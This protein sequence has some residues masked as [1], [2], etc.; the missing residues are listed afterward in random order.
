MTPRA[1]INQLQHVLSLGKLTWIASN[2]VQLLIEKTSLNFDELRSLR[3]FGLQTN[4]ATQTEQRLFDSNGAGSVQAGSPIDLTVPRQW[5]KLV[6]ARNMKDLLSFPNAHVSVPAAYLLLELQK[7]E[8]AASFVEGDTTDQLPPVQHRYHQAVE[9]WNILKSC[10]DHLNAEGNLMYF[11]PKPSEIMPGFDLEILERRQLWEPGIRKFISDRDRLEVRQ[12]IFRSC[13]GDLLR[14]TT[15]DHA[16]R[17][18]LQST[19]VFER[20]LREG[21]AMYLA[22]NTP[23]KLATEGRASAMTALPPP[24]PAW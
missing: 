24:E 1:A 21:M 2:E 20:H 17:T 7:G 15:P 14:D 19:D 22:D 18:F 9:L 5:S 23:E 11:G 8:S 12:Q 6:V 3:D 10:A 16:F 13:L 4:L